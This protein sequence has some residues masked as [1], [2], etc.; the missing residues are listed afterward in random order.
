MADPAGSIYHARSKQILAK[1]HFVRD[2]VYIDGEMSV[3]CSPS[4]TGAD[5]LTK[6]ASV[7]VVCYDKKLWV[8]FDI[9]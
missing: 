1:Y 6:H 5:M 8:V 2:R 4:Q 7:A 9:V 3:K